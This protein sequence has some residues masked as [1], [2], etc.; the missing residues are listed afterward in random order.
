MFRALVC[1]SHRTSAYSAISD[2]GERGDAFIV[3]L[4]CDEKQRKTNKF[5]LPK[6]LRLR[7][8]RPNIAKTGGGV[9]DLIFLARLVLLD[10]ST[11]W[12]SFG[13]RP[14]T[15]KQAKGRVRGHSS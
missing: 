2:D 7:L 12:L 10:H 1:Q 3:L 5:V 4:A 13:I 11:N 14:S 15:A 9:D 6:P 8:R